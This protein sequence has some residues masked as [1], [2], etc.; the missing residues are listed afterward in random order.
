VLQAH[1]TAALTGLLRNA[2]N[3]PEQGVI[4]PTAGYLHAPAAQ[5]SAPS[6]SL[7][8][9]ARGAARHARTD[10]DGEVR[11]QRGVESRHGAGRL[12]DCLFLHPPQPNLHSKRQSE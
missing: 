12:L 2:Q 6:G 4:A 8:I 3:T 1:G 5:S 10:D 9:P 7:G 11:G